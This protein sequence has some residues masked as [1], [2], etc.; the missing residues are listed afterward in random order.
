MTHSESAYCEIERL[1]ANATDF[2]AALARLQKKLSVDGDIVS[3]AGREKTIEVFGEPLTPAEVVSRICN[4]VKTTGLDAVLKFTR[5]IDRVELNR[6]TIRISEAEI[7]AAHRQVESRFVECVRTIRD[8]ITHF[9][10]AILHK[11]VNVRRDPAIELTQRYMPLKRIGVCVPGGAAAYPSSLL[12]TAVPAQ[13]AGVEEIAVVA[14]PTEFG[15]NNPHLLA[16]CRELGIHEV[17]RIGGA[18]AVAALAYGIDGI[19]PVSKIVGPGNLF[20]ALAKRLVFGEVDIDSFAGPSE[21]VVIADENCKPN[22]VALDL[23]AQAEHSPGSSILVTWSSS[24][25]EAVEKAINQIAPSLPR[26]GLALESLKEFGRMILVRNREQAIEV[27]NRLAPEHLQI[28]TD[29]ADQLAKSLTNAGAIFVGHVTTV[30]LGDYVAGPSHVLPTG[31]TAVWANGLC[32]NDFLRSSSLIKYDMKSIAHDAPAV[33]VIAEIEG[34]TAH[35][36]SVLR[37]LE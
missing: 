15:A 19:A 16:T 29:D 5:Q 10:R 22:W 14:P 27:T 13:V 9:Q 36:E 35:R 24:V 8:N 31:A 23:L 11:N 28:A 6:D 26:G 32:A 25:I 21:V 1:D 2:D 33:K 7:D 20:V 30:A 3:V 12:M 34:L 4:D 17:Y 37:R 18:Q